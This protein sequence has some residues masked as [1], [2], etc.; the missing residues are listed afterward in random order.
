MDE[1]REFIAVLDAE[2]DVLK[3]A[4]IMLPSE[5]HPWRFYS[6][7][8]DGEHEYEH[9][10][11]VFEAGKLALEA[12]SCA[13]AGDDAG[14]WWALAKAQQALLRSLSAEGKTKARKL[15]NAKGGQSKDEKLDFQVFCIADDL[16][17]AGYSERGLA[18]KI[19]DKIGGRDPKSEKLIRK[20]LGEQK[21]N[22]L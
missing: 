9:H 12:E 2:C 17:A 8:L 3:K 10:R 15:G 22:H 19:V 11:S 7:P 13:K 21:R 1:I 5:A 20:I 16:R 18:R 6:C 14:A 4:G